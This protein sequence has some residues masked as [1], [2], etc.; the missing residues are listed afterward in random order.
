MAVEYPLNLDL[1]DTEVLHAFDRALNDMTDNE[2]NAA[3]A[4]A[5]NQLAAT[6]NNKVDKI[7]N[8]SLV[9]D[10]DIEKLQGLSNYDD[11]EVR[12]MIAQRVPIRES[13]SLAPDWFLERLR[14]VMLLDTPTNRVST[15]ND[16][17]NYRRPGIWSS[18]NADLS[19]ISNIPDQSM[20][21]ELIVFYTTAEDIGIQVLIYA[22]GRMFIR[23][24]DNSSND[25]V[26]GNWQ[27][28]ATDADISD[29]NTKVLQSTIPLN[30]DLDD[31]FES[32]YKIF[33][34]QTSVITASLSNIP[35]DI[36]SG[37]IALEAY[38]SGSNQYIQRLT[39]MLDDGSAGNIY[40]RTKTIISDV[41]SI[42]N[43]FKIGMTELVPQ[44]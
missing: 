42:S 24:F 16:I 30:A 22:D 27:R 40:Y 13:Y 37:T 41:T 8:Y 36:S 32:D 19:T 44:P 39:H 3:I 5:I 11:T 33:H 18:T 29:K 10:L 14:Y 38:K 34:S 25:V 28:L 12:A 4:A 2:I 6:V 20:N 26:F 17:N 7:Q 23:R 9:S 31:Y 15:D 21:F 1:T 43:W 35:Y